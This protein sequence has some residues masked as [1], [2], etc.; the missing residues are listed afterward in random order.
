MM[1]CRDR[2]ST[3]VVQNG[4]RQNKQNYLCRQCYR[5]FIDPY[6]PKGY[7]P[8]VKKHCLKLYLNGMG[9]RGIE[10]ATGV[11]HNTVIN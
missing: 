11:C 3:Q 7:L 1:Q 6:E 5:Q 8:E 10:R 4:R 9:F 2:Q